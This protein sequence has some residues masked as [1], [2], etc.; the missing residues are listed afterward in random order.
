MIDKDGSLLLG[1][2][3][4]KVRLKRPV[5]YQVDPGNR[6]QLVDS[7]YTLRPLSSAS[8]GA[9]IS[10]KV[11][12]YDHSIP[13]V[14]DPLLDY[15]TYL[16]GNGNDFAGGIAVDAFGS[17][18][19]VGTTASLDF[20]ATSNAVF[21]SLA[22][23]DPGTNCEDAFIA[24][25][26]PSG[27]GLVYST[28]LGGTA[29]DFGTAITVDSSGNAY[30]T[31]STNSSDFPTTPGAL[32]R[33]CGGTCFNR[34]GFV[35]KL[36]PTGSALL[37]STYLGGSGEDFTT[38]IALYQGKALIS[39][40][41]GSTD[42]PV[43]P[44]AFKTKM[45]GQG[46]SFA[47]ELNSTG[48]ALIF[49]TF[50]GE[51]DLQDA[52]PGIAVDGL[53]NSYLAG[54]TLSSNFP[55]TAAAFHTGFLPGLSNNLYIAKLNAT[56]SS[57][58]YSALIGGAGGNSIAVDKSGN[59][60]FVGSAGP[61]FPISPG[62]IN[63]SCNDAIFGNENGLI[64][65][66][67]SADGSKLLYSAHLC[68]DRS[69]AGGIGPDSLG[70]LVITGATDSAQMPTTVGA[71]QTSIRNI[72]CFSD[73]LLTKLN[74]TGTARIYSSYLGGN[75]SDSGD[76]LALDGSGNVYLSGQTSS[77]NFPTQ[78]P[79]QAVNGGSSDAFIAKISIPR[80][81][82]SLYPS[83]ISF[84]GEGLG[85]VSA[86]QPVTV[87]NVGTSLMSMST[88]AVSGD[89][90]AASN[91][92]SRLSPTAHC[93]INI[94]F[95]PSA[96]GTRNGLLT[97][98]DSVGA[99]KIPLA[100]TGIRGAVVL[101]AGVYTINNQP[102]GTTSPPLP[103]TI[104]N[105]G[106]STLN[107]TG[108][109]LSNGP[110]FNFVGNTNCFSPIA[111]LASCTVDI[112]FTPPSFFGGQEFATLTLTDNAP[113]SPQGLS[114]VGNG[115]GPGIYFSAGGMRFD[116]QPIGGTSSPQTVAL[117]NGLSTAIT[118]TSIG[119]T[120]DFVATHTCG[121]TLQVGAF[122]YIMVRFKPTSTGIR[123]GSIM[124][125]D[126][127]SG[128]PQV[129]PLLGSGQTQAAVTL[130]PTSISFG[131]EKVGTTSTPQTVLLTDIGGSVLSIVGVAK[132]G[133]DPGDFGVATS[134]GLSLAPG[135]GCTVVV[136]FTPKATGTRSA[137]I[138]ITDSVVGSPQKITVSGTGI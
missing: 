100:G 136:R 97:V 15:S 76:G 75:N 86:S 69:S 38:G 109:E 58:V 40:F 27:T 73:A 25:I 47:V 46:S 34:D 107:I 127:A 36:D 94:S 99:Q 108:I 7:R 54:T 102:I 11:A 78:Q 2:E 81:L 92:G 53:G 50:L 41:S 132:G 17:A 23:C 124:V 56:G 95:K 113:N 13:L 131:S 32:Q 134:C 62:A 14:I 79:F 128:S 98:T 48:S 122:C 114:I 91:C 18:Y 74:S 120:G 55:V 138:S 30:V 57:L 103:I 44:G 24:K 117:I 45:E 137:V 83:K 101:T 90:L 126:S 119:K 130:V 87:A 68:P 70:N 4:G 135:A 31:G 82:I 104:R 116:E 21:P 29:D 49:G 72:C 12:A 89:F 59:T 10:V 111:P 96:T 9:R 26:D 37:Y 8:V 1:T 35:T 65:A 121:S 84:T 85:I 129:L 71:F 115:V 64:A 63:E 16:G 133:T 19:V 125:S 20:P 118:I 52:G 67:L 106:N 60:Y 51:V 110:D 80:P 93:T 22:G 33:S 123:Q 77:T 61:F 39:G 66:K 5:T 42:F 88:V 105:V 3:I 43:T 28:Y 6:K 112:S